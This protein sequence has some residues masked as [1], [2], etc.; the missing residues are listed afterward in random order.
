MTVC[1]VSVTCICL[2]PNIVTCSVCPTTY[3]L[4]LDKHD[5]ESMMVNVELST[6]RHGYY[7][8]LINR[9]GGLTSKKCVFCVCG[10]NITHV[11][12]FA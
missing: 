9:L 4:A 5:T 8:A 12:V 2:L 7:R 3:L 10:W 11:Y 6:V 1:K